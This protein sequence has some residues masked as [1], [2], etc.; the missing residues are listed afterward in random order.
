[1]GGG[2]GQAKVSRY[3]RGGGGGSQGQAGMVHSTSQRSQP[4]AVTLEGSCHRAKPNLSKL[5]QHAHE[6]V[7]IDDPPVG[8][9]A[10]E[11]DHSGH[12]LPSLRGR[13][14]CTQPQHCQ[15]KCYLEPEHRILRLRRVSCVAGLSNKQTYTQSG[16]KGR[17]PG[18][19]RG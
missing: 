12:W 7:L 14:I 9:L 5:A 19:G 17:G 11:G 8:A 4:L 15:D 13:Q 10:L 2:A 16:G 6:L 1:M 3:V 18:G